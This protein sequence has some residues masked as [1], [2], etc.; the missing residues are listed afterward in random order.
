MPMRA[1]THIQKT[2]PGPPLTRAEATP[3]RFPV[4]TCAPRVAQSAPNPDTPSS[5][6][7]DFF[8]FLNIFPKYRSCTRRRRAV[9]NNP[10]P[11]RIRIKN[12]PHKKPLNFSKIAIIPS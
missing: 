6:F 7:M 12:H 2:A 3:T 8:T 11:R 5:F 10:V 9:R 1:V 4:P